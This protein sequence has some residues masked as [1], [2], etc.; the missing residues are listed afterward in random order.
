ML[1]WSD[2]T[3]SMQLGK[4]IYDVATSHGTT[5]AR[6]QDPQPSTSQSAPPLTTF[7]CRT[8]TNEKILMTESA[9]AGQLSLVPT[10]ANSATHMEL[11]NQVR[12]QH[13]KRSRMRVLDDVVKPEEMQK[14]LLKA[15]GKD[16]VHKTRVKREPGTSGRTERSSRSGRS[17][18]RA[19]S[20][21]SGSD[22]GYGREKDY[23][24][25][26][27]FVVADD[28]E[29]GEEE[30][31][32]DEDGAAWGSKKTKSKKAKKG[33]K[34]KGSE[35]MDELELAD[36]RLEAKDRERKKAKMDKKKSREYVDS[37]DDDSEVD[38]ADEMDGVGQGD[39]DADDDMDVESEDE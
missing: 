25:D 28:D 3:M 6:P 29:D 37:D 33:K 4:D 5:L 15:E 17:T 32:E 18:R 2:G 26:D 34:R 27:G 19:L 7:V 22:R 13:V 35:S 24:E 21:D 30:E 20:E 1:R 36:R 31:T 8:L 11:A 10:S 12:Q 16:I 38:D 39:G 9:I 23:D 14:M